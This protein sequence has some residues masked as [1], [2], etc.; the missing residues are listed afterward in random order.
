MIITAA[1]SKLA[2]NS[3]LTTS[4]TCILNLCMCVITL[5]YINGSLQYYTINHHYHW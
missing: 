3:K 4:S 5:S 1:G 2:S